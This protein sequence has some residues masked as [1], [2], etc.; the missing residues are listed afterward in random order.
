MVDCSKTHGCIAVEF[1]RVCCR[2]GLRMVRIRLSKKLDTN[3]GIQPF[4]LC[5]HL[6]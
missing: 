4:S 5:V 6:P 1:E 3:A 2:V